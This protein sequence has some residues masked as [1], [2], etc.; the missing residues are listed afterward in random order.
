MWDK[1]PNAWGIRSGSDSAILEIAA[2]TY[3]GGTDLLMSKEGIDKVIGKIAE[4]KANTKL[5]WQDEGTMQ[6]ALINDEVAGGTIC[7]TRP[8]S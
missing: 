5:W 1:H 3:F 8:W 6:T 7:T 4:L 2:K